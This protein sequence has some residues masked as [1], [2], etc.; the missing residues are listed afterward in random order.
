MYDKIQFVKKNIFFERQEDALKQL[1]SLYYDT[2][3][4]SN[5]N[6]FSSLQQLVPASHILLGTDYPFG[7]ASEMAGNLQGI[8]TYSGFNEQDRQDI[9]GQNALQLFPRLQNQQR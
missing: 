2:A 6:V 8:A 7:P 3:I 1:R 4:T 9:V 5:A